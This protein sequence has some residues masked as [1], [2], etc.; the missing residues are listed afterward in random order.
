[1][2][3]AQILE[4]IGFSKP[5]TIG[6][7]IE[8][9]SNIIILLSK[10]GRHTALDFL[11]LS[12]TPKGAFEQGVVKDPGAVGKVIANKTKKIK[13]QN[14]YSAVAA[15][16][17]LVTTYDAKIPK[18][19][20]RKK[21]TELVQAEAKHAFP[22]IYKELYLDYIVKPADSDNANP[23]QED[24]T[25][26]A[27]HKK[28]I[29]NRLDALKLAKIPARI[30]DVDYFALE[31]GYHLLKPDIP[32]EIQNENVAILDI[33]TARMLLTVYHQ[34]ELIH[35]YHHSYTIKGLSNLVRYHVC[36][37]QKNQE[38]MEK[39]EL[40]DESLNTDQKQQLINQIQYL[41]KTFTPDSYSNKINL[42]IASGRATLI[43]NMQP[44]IEQTLGV[45]TILAN[46]FSRIK[47]NV[48]MSEAQLKKIAPACLLACGLALRNVHHD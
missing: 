35:F 24:I 40:K 14:L 36:Y 29:Q 16:A 10:H 20:N 22:K 43:P 4:S 7:D 46:P 42:M 33:S 34:G 1:M 39:F 31:R 15:P 25:I 30:L 23:K 5:K 37:D 19:N 32:A 8:P 17:K 47:K 38:G 45:K 18:E 26:I 44:L 48:R 28:A 13:R 27:A 3:F 9:S 2:D 11:S 21:R 12:E 6:V 41:L